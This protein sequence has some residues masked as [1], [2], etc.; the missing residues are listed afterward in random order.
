MQPLTRKLHADAP[1]AASIVLQN[2][3]GLSAAA[4]P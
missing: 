1:D 2:T 3:R 4:S